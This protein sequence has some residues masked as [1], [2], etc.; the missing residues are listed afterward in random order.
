MPSMGLLLS[1]VDVVL[2]WSDWAVTGQLRQRARFRPGSG[3]GSGTWCRT[4]EIPP[5][6]IGEEGPVD[7]SMRA[8]LGSPAARSPDA[9]RVRW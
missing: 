7:T 6:R 1:V 4:A 5:P 9:G 2:A 8:R 3:H